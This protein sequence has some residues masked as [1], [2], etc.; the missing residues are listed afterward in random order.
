MASAADVVTIVG[1]TRSRVDGGRFASEEE[2]DE[3]FMLMFP[4]FSLS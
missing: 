1:M 2:D 3:S 4:E